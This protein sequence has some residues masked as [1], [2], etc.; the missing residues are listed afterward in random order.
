MKPG[1]ADMPLASIVWP[2]VDAGL[3]APAE[4]IFPPRH[5]DGAA[6]DHAGVGA[7]DADVGDRQVL[8]RCGDCGEKS[9]EHHR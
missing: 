1:M 7:D 4:R 9:R 2:A 3:P 5:D 8:S 6:F